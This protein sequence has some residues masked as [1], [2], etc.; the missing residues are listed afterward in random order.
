M[1][2]PDTCQALQKLNLAIALAGGKLVVS[3]AMR[4]WDM[5]AQAYAEFLAGRRKDNVNPPGYSF[6]EAGRAIDL[7]L[8]QLGIK[9][10]RL[11]RIALPIGWQPIVPKPDASLS[12]AWHWEYPGDW[13]KHYGSWRNKQVAQCA[14]IDAGQWEETNHHKLQNMFLQCQLNRLFMAALACD[15]LIGPKTKNVLAQHGL[16]KLS[17]E[18]ALEKLVQQ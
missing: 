5:Q 17:V 13:A 14:V 15:G 6:H 8:S 18:Q 16:Q 2:T 3:D 12:E 10:E 1:L 4:S 9:L 11:W 7:D